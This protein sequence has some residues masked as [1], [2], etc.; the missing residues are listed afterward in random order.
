[1]RSVTT[2]LHTRYRKKCR[3]P[4]KH[5]FATETAALRAAEH[6]EFALGTPFWAYLCACGWWHL[7]TK[8]QREAQPTRPKGTP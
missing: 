1:M 4:R 8:P 2:N 6:R 7:T 3:K 5:R